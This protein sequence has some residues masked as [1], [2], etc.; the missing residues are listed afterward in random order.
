MFR[1]MWTKLLRSY[2]ID[3]VSVTPAGR[4]DAD[5]VAEFLRGAARASC[6]SRP[7]V[8]AGALWR[9]SGGAV[10]GSALTFRQGVVHIDLFPVEGVSVDGDQDNDAPRLRVRRDNS[11]D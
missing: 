2:V 5:A 4:F 7:A 9:L 11:R 3:A 10:S 6:S 1:L 8:G